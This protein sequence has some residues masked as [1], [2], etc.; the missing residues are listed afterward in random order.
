MP[1]ISFNILPPS[2]CGTLCVWAPIGQF[3]WSAATV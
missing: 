1:N 2:A 3:W